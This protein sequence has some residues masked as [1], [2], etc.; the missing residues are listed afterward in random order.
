VNKKSY[1][2]DELESEHSSTI[3]WLK[4]KTNDIIKVQQEYSINF[5]LLINNLKDYLKN[6]KL[7]EDYK[8]NANYLIK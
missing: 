2:I 1:I 4:I 3:N 7:S 8:E 5:D 6:N